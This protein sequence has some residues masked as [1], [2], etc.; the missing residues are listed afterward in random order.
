MTDLST[1]PAQPAA[2]APAQPTALSELW[3]HARMI[4]DSDIIPQAYRGKPANCVI[5]IE[6]AQRM[7]SSPMLV[8]QNLDIIQGKP[9]W[10]SKFLIATVNACGRFTPI[11]FRFEGKPNTKDWSCTAYAKEKSTEEVLDGVTVSI[12]MADTEG[13]LKKAGSK[14]QTMP[15]LMLMYRSAAFWA[16][17]YC[18]EVS[19]G[20]HNADE[21]EDMA[22][23]Q[24]GMPD[25]IRESILAT[26]AVVVPE[27]PTSA[28]ATTVEAPSAPA[29]D[30]VSIPEPAKKPTREPGED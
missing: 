7:G 3:K 26:G 5:A 29:T 9:G 11:R 19:M 25:D 4:A 30:R 8:M 20:L 15:Q 27:L 1:V 14:W 17:V 24:S 2:I 10:S 18:P 12:A 23:R 16:R 13:W 6:L 21:I 28:Q 22:V